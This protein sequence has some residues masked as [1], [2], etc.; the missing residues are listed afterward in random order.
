[1]KPRTFLKQCSIS[2]VAALGIGLVASS[3]YATDFLCHNIGGPRD[4]GANC[5]MTGN[6]SYVFEGQTITVAPNHFLGIIIGGPQFQFPV[7]ITNPSVAAHLAHGDGLTT[8]FFDPP[9]HLASAIGPP[10]SFQ[11]GMHRGEGLCAAAGAWQLTRGRMPGVG[12]P[13]STTRD[14]GT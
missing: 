13:P 6:C 14:E 5:D 12:H 2:A 8:V 3:V 9:L 10:S 4:L 1:M 11:C 7:D